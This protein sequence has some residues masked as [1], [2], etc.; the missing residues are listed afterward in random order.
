MRNRQ[1]EFRKP[2]PFAARF[3]TAFTLV[4]A[5]AFSHCV[6]AQSGRVPNVKPNATAGRPQTDDQDDTVKLRTDEVLLPVSVRNHDGKVPTY[7]DKK[8]FIV[9]EDGKPQPITAVLRLPAN[10]LFIVDLSG[11]PNFRKD[12]SINSAIAFHMV[13]AL[14]Q[15]DRAAVLTYADRIDLIA[16]WTTDKN[17]VGAALKSKV[18]PG[19]RA[20]FYRC[21]KY[22]AQEILPK[23]TG[24][25][26]VVLL[27]DGV[28]SFNQTGFT[29]ALAAL[30]RARATVYVVN[31]NRVII[32]DLR[33]R[34]FHKLSW[35]EMLDPKVK[36]RYDPI[37]NYVHQLEAAE[38]TLKGL[39]EETGGLVWDADKRI[40]TT[41]AKTAKPE[42]VEVQE[43]PLTAAMLASQVVAEIGTEFIVAYSTDRKSNDKIFHTVKVF[44]TRPEIKIRTRRGVYANLQPE[45]VGTKQ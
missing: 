4:L 32:K 30:H 2:L 9:A 24:R 21:V 34:V 19:I 36:K 40:E 5:I 43:R 8:D 42:Y 41:A 3:K 33:E 1:V 44:V 23:V 18:K 12:T 45:A 29:E 26:A 16:D 6:Q 13:K 7:L 38:L 25:R 31:Q 10:V 17:A 22:A 15:E 39:A 28:D 37:R 35:Y 11:E 20:D 14:G 27:S